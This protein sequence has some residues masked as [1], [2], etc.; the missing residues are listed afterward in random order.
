MVASGLPRRVA[1]SR[2]IPRNLL[3]ETPATPYAIAMQSHV[4]AAFL[5]ALTLLP[6]LAAQRVST[7]AETDRRTTTV[8]VSAEDGTTLAGASIGYS[9]PTWHSSYDAAVDKPSGV[10][11]RLG[12]NWWTTLD[13][14]GAIEIGGTKIEPGSYYLGIGAAKD[15]A[16]TLLVFDSRKAMQDGVLPGSTVLYRG[17]VL[18][19]AAAP[20]TLHKGT[21]PATVALME[22]EIAADAADPS[23]GK[24][25]IRWGKHELTAPVTFHLAPLKSTVGPKK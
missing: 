23:H 11:S 13:T 22:I 17:E 3:A 6:A 24:L 19:T 9:A 20:M 5:G 1:E 10:Y 12:K 18:A 4:A 21:L 8:F 15:G 7:G 2:A 16:F 14:L 25:A